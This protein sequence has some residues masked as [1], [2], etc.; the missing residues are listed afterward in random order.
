METRLYGAYS[1]GQ[2]FPI[3]PRLIF[4]GKISDMASSLQLEVFLSDKKREYPDKDVS[5][6]LTFFRSHA[7]CGHSN[8]RSRAPCFQILFDIL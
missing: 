2:G 1:T 5:K 6:P 7:P 4:G 8:K 3:G